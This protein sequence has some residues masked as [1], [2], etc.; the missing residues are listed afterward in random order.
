MSKN[1]QV[2]HPNFGSFCYI[3]IFSQIVVFLF[4]N[5]KNQ[6]FKQTTMAWRM[7]AAMGE[8]QA[9]GLGILGGLA[10]TTGTSSKHF[11][12]VHMILIH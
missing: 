1:K 12:Y 9:I 7:L 6:L 4:F 5:H 2:T 8:N 10:V 11:S 3:L